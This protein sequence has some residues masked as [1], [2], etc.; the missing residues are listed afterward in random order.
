[1]KKL[2]DYGLKN[3]GYEAFKK[4]IDEVEELKW[5]ELEDG[6]INFWGSDSKFEKSHPPGTICMLYERDFTGEYICEVVEVSYYTSKMDG[7]GR[8]V[9]FRQIGIEDDSSEHELMKGLTYY[10]NTWC[11]KK[12]I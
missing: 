4:V 10:G 5:P 8:Y 7:G 2:E 6:S 3:I 11:L 12:I 1:M 9:Y